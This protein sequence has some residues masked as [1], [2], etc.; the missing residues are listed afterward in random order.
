MTAILTGDM[1]AVTTGSLNKRY[2]QANLDRDNRLSVRSRETDKGTLTDWSLIVRSNTFIFLFKPVYDIKHCPISE[3][4]QGALLI[5][6]PNDEFLSILHKT[7][8]FDCSML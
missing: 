8:Q 5:V 4:D 1:L 6:V 2:Q 7:L 3:V